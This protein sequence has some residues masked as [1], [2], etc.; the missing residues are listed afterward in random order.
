MSEAAVKKGGAE[1][2]RELMRLLPT[3]NIEDYCKAGIWQ[4]NLIKLDMEVVEA[5]RREAGAPDPPP[6]SK[7]PMPSLPSVPKALQPGLVKPTMALPAATMSMSRLAGQALNTAVRPTGSPA[8]A[9]GVSHGASQAGQATPSTSSVQPSQEAKA[10]VQATSSTTAPSAVL[11]PTGSAVADL[12]QIALFVSKWRLEP[13]RTKLLLA[14]LTPLRRRYVMQ[15]F[16][17]T[18][19]TKPPVA[20][21]EEYIQQCE[22]SNV[23]G[24]SATTTSVV[25][26]VASLG[27]NGTAGTATSSCANPAPVGNA[28]S[29]SVKRTLTPSVQSVEPAKRPRIVGPNTQASRVPNTTGP[30]GPVSLF[31]RLGPTH[32]APG[33]QI[34]KPNVPKNPMHMAGRTQGVSPGLQL[35]QTQFAR[36]QY[37]M[38]R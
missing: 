13:A 32:M 38:R 16:K 30:S 17:H 15:N 34:Q 11:S 27:V 28:A 9:M 33:V 37:A 25:G 31:T 6:L 22:R 29:T 12:R 18:P 7:V 10:K 26:V 19:G 14:R 23:W 5:H 2:F 35:A 1:L 24:V 3:V 36:Q 21:L 8:S 4:N 20:S